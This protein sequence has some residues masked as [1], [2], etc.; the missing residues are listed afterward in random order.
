MLVSSLAIIVMAIF[1]AL[2][3]GVISV[4]DRYQIGIKGN[5]VVEVN[6]YNNLFTL[7]FVIGL[8]FYFPIWNL[9][10]DW[11]VILYSVLVQAV[12]IGYST[13]FKKMTIF[14]SVI[15]AKLA[16]LLIPIAVY[17][18]T[19]KLDLKIYFLA[20]FTTLIVVFWLKK[21][22]DAKKYLDGVIII[23]P[24][25]TIQAFASPLLVGNN[26]NQLSSII[27][28]T[29]STLVIR[30]IISALMMLF[31]QKSF[32]LKNSLNSNNLFIY[33]IRSILTIIA[34]FTF[35]IVTSDKYS[36]LGWI[37]LNMTSL[38]GVLASSLFLKEKNTKKEILLICFIT[39]IML[40][41]NF[42]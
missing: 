2:S 16:D 22:G 41:Q 13:L 28:F 39:A 19:G 35:V 18:S 25:L 1:S 14:K 36:A 15:S 32:Q 24:L 17:L 38:Y 12:A 27:A 30:F 11:K 40:I 37:F 42:I 31:Y 33:I 20:V 8:T 10:T 29:L 23:V 3:R 5:S 26:K 34:Q 6:L 4:I 9:I 7:L 21:K